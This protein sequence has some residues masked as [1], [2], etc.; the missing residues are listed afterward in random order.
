MTHDAQLRKLENSTDRINAKVRR[1]FEAKLW[2]EANK[3]PAHVVKVL[4]DAAKDLAAKRDVLVAESSALM[5][6]YAEAHA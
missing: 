3:A 5:D 2:A 1:A 6:A 4:D